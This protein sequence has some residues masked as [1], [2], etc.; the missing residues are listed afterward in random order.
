M[1]FVELANFDTPIHP[2]C[3]VQALL[4]YTP[5]M[6][7]LSI[8]KTARPKCR[9]FGYSMGTGGVKS[10]QLNQVAIPASAVGHSAT[11]QHSTPTLCTGI[12]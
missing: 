7:Q 8:L 3:L 12:G 1:K 6:D 11:T 10:K 9:P 4:T 2:I 5:N